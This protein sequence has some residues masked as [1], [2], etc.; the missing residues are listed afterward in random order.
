M[1]ICVLFTLGFNFIGNDW[2]LSNMI[3][4]NPLCSGPAHKDERKG[5]PLPHKVG[6]GNQHS[7]NETS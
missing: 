4:D 3:Y 7:L 5:V 2:Q 6:L 1:K